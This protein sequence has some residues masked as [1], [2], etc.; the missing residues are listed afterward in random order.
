[1]CDSPLLA[2]RDG[3]DDVTVSAAPAA[4]GVTDDIRMKDAEAEVSHKE[5]TQTNGDKAAACRSSSAAEF[6]PESGAESGVAVDAV[7]PAPL[8]CTGSSNPPD[9]ETNHSPPHKVNINIQFIS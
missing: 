5:P 6:G 4:E 9:R 1:M 2:G 3:I 7:E 8:T